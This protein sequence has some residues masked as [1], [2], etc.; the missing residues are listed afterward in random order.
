MNEMARLRDTVP[1]GVSPRAAVPP[2]GHTGSHG[3]AGNRRDRP[4]RGVPLPVPRRCH[5]DT[6]VRQ[7]SPIRGYVRD[8][9]ETSITKEV[10]VSG[11]GSSTP[12]VFHPARAARP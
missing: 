2:A 10:A 9:V 11:P 1:L 7:H 5:G 6:P 3:P 8:G 12:V 4:G